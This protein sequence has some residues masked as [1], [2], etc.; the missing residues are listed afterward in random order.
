MAISFD[1][2]SS[3]ISEVN[4]ELFGIISPQNPPHFEIFK[5]WLDSGAHGDL[6]YLSSNMSIF[7]RE[8][9]INIWPEC[10]SVI[11]V[12]FPYPPVLKMKSNTEDYGRI[13]AY[14]CQ[15]D[16]HFRIKRELNALVDQII[17]RINQKIESRIFCDTAPVLEKEYG[18]LAGL[19]WIGKNSLLI[20]PRW[21]S[22][23]NIGV[24]LLNLEV[25]SIKP[26]IIKDLCGE[27]R[28]CIDIC[29]THCIQEDRTIFAGDCISNL[30]IEHRKKIPKGL[31]EKM[32]DWIFGC[33]ICQNVCPWNEKWMKTND[34]E[35]Y[36]I[37]PQFNL[38]KLDN[39]SESQYAEKYQN[40]PLSRINYTKFLQNCLIAIGN[41]ENTG[42]LP[43][44]QKMSNI[45]HPFQIEKVIEWAVHRLTN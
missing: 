6:H 29:P 43:T 45:K 12:G 27:C 1:H 36:T 18:Y 4:F 14:A 22:F 40:T 8:H 34:G 33:D 20:N 41:S 2:L 7:N 16:Y 32:G 28:M 30:T 17:S 44:I 11:I 10:K 38:H 37:S 24:V 31:R 42:L 9:I 13:A 21:G 5:K 3:I 15:E 35:M 39:F 26:I 23:F 25:T 19:G